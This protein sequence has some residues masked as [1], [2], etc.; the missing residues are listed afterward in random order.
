MWSALRASA[1]AKAA[2]AARDQYTALLPI[3]EEVSGPTHPDT[4]TA[5]ANLAQWTALASG[6]E[7][8]GGSISNPAA[9]R[10]RRR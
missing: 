2:A 8:T 10:R 1:S 5:R 7:S 3:C 9:R 4:L 6:S